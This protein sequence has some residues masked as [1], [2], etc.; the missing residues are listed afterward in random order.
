MT[1][2]GTAHV[3]AGGRGGSRARMEDLSQKPVD[4]HD[5]ATVNVVWAGMLAA[6]LNA[7]ARDGRPAP[8]GAE[9]PVFGLATFALTKAVAKEK[10]G[11][12]AREPLTEPGDDGSHPRGRGLRY[13]L[14]ELVTCSRCLGTWSA[15]GLVG[16]RVARPREGRIVAAVLATAAI[17]DLLQTGFTLL[18]AKA[19]ATQSGAQVAE[20]QAR[21]ISAVEQ[22]PEPAARAAR[23]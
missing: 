13:V 7:T 3:S 16:L 14:G 15:L 2:L 6:L 10:V 4:P 11:A 12:W 8:A 1:D 23:R 18:T 20:S 19:N 9:L 5:Y 22:S 17:N 21:R